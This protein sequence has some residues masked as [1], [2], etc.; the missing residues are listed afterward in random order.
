M[1]KPSRRSIEAPDQLDPDF[2]HFITEDGFTVLRKEVRGSR[3]WDPRD[4]TW[5]DVTTNSGEGST[6]DHATLRRR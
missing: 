3:V 6:T 5:A 1:G 4:G 2:D